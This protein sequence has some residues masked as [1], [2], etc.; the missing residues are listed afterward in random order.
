MTKQEFQ[1]R[2]EAAL[3]VAVQNA[4]HQLNR[5][6]CREL[7][8]R[9]YGANHSSDLLEVKQA[10]HA[11][12]LGE[13]LFYRI[14]DIA[15]IESRPQATVLFVRASGHTPATFERTWDPSGNGPF[16][17]LL[18]KTIKVVEE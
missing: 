6:L 5:T 16:K 4:E 2:F 1:E 3:E 17:Q 7:H 9:L 12:Y 8:I 11:L 14:V 13:D 10:T 18:A 15:V